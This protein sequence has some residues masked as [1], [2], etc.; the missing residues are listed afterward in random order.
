M[1]TE[2]FLSQTKLAARFFGRVPTSGEVIELLFAE[3]DF[4]PAL[5]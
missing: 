1:V 3:R 5:G 2:H 4:E